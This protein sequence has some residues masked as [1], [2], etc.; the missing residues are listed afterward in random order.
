M[1]TTATFRIVPDRAFSRLE[2]TG[3]EPGE[4]TIPTCF[5]Q[6]WHSA[7]AMLSALRLA[8]GGLAIAASYRAPDQ[9]RI[10]LALETVRI[11]IVA[12]EGKNA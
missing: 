4:I 10:Q 1:S 7:P 12:A 5:A 3:D 2:I 6:L 9:R 11:A 8:E